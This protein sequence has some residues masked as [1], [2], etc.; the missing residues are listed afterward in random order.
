VSGRDARCFRVLGR[1]CFSIS[2]YAGG[3]SIGIVRICISEVVR[4]CSWSETG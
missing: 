4:R 1:F 3:D 2:L